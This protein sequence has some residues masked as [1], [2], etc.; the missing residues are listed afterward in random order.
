MDPK[1]P[2][3]RSASNIV[4]PK[5]YSASLRGDLIALGRPHLGFGFD[6]GKGSSRSL[7]IFGNDLLRLVGESGNDLCPLVGDSG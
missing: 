3:L 1:Y 7:D 6:N 5:R 2:I 4:D